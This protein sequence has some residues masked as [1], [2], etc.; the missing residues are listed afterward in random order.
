M[1]HTAVISFERATC[2]CGQMRG[3]WRADG[4]AIGKFTLRADACWRVHVQL[5][6]DAAAGDL[7]DY[8]KESGPT[9]S[10]QGGL[11]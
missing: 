4:E 7:F 8:R 6:D 5:A 11:F 3:I 1:K 2:S 10:A 9:V